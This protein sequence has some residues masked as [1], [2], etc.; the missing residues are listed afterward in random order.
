[1]SG[2]TFLTMIS[3]KRIAP[4]NIA[5]SPLNMRIAEA[6]MKMNQCDLD[7]SQQARDTRTGMMAIMFGNGL[8][9]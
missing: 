3:M 2:F 5:N 1:M 4:R 9:L 6:A 7:C 8:E